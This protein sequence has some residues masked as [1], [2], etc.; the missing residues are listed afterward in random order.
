MDT[1]LIISGL[2]F[3]I[4]GLLAGFLAR[5]VVY[6]VLFVILIYVGMTILDQIGLSTSWEVFVELRQSL[7][8]AGYA[9]FKFFSQLLGGAPVLLSGLFFVGCIVGVLG[10]S[11]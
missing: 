11:R 2:V 4:L 1:N 8:T 6:I 7:M 10:S 3:L 5:K 9:A